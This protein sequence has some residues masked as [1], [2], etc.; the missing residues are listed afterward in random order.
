MQKQTYKIKNGAGF[1]D[2]VRIK[3][4]DY[5]VYT[6]L[7]HEKFFCDYLKE[8]AGEAKMPSAWEQ[9]GLRENSARSLFFLNVPGTGSFFVKHFKQPDFFQQVRFVF[10]KSKAVQE[11]HNLLLL[12]ADGVSAP[13][14]VGVIEKGNGLYTETARLFLKNIPGA[15][16][17]K[18]FFTEIKPGWKT[19]VKIIDDAAAFVN[20]FISKGFYHR[21]FHIG[22]ILIKESAE[23][24]CELF[25]SDLHRAQKIEKLNR[26]MA[27]YNIAHLVYSLNTV[28]P[29]TLCWHFMKKFCAL[30]P[31]FKADGQDGLDAKKIRD[32]SRQVIKKAKEIR[33]EHLISRMN[34]VL[35]NSTGFTVIKSIGYNIYTRRGT[36]PRAVLRHVEKHDHIKDNAPMK[37]EKNTFKR[38]LSRINLEDFPEKGRIYV[39]EYI[40][41]FSQVLVKNFLRMHRAKSAWVAAEGFRLRNLPTPLCI[42]LVEKKFMPFITTGCLISYEVPNALPLSQ[43][44][45]ENYSRHFAGRDFY[46][47]KKQFVMHLM[48]FVRDIHSKGVFHYD[49][50]ANNI[51]VQKA[52][53]IGNA[54]M[55]WLDLDRVDFCR[56]LSEGQVIKNLAQLNASIPGMISR[57]DRLRFFYAYQERFRKFKNPKAAL[58]RIMEITIQRRHI[59]P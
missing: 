51:L 46:I 12:A 4:G 58:R 38:A 21:D 19:A 14:P 52:E 55:H 39:K 44:I 7:A 18:D 42:G 27:V 35:K 9:K 32:F 11:F 54:K 13:E 47:A 15:M 10:E 8:L 24:R 48:E 26:G 16:S 41:T 29:F 59:W 1:I 28:A 25:I 53:D 3:D 43:F 50:K 45:V 30:N 33:H 40:Y 36:D 34:R 37:L 17:L 22:N 31:D 5:A 23:G 49:M 6:T 57:A 2:A 56:E 20:L